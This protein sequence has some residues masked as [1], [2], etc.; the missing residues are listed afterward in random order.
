M[1]LHHVSCSPSKIPYV[2][3]SPVRLQTEIQRRPSPSALVWAK[4]SLIDSLFRR[5]IV[6]TPKIVP[7]GMNI[8]SIPATTIQKI[9]FLCCFNFLPP[10]NT[11]TAIHHPN[12]MNTDETITNIHPM[13][14]GGTG[15]LLSWKIFPEIMRSPM[16]KCRSGMLENTAVIPA[17]I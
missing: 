2:G 3:F 13:K 16:M 6:K 11:N 15:V 8:H 1:L 14:G 12:I 10:M 17:N 7:K 4:I 5:I 9:R